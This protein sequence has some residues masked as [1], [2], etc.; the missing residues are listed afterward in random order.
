[1]TRHPA[2]GP[3]R[4]DTKHHTCQWGGL[5]ATPAS[6]AIRTHETLPD[7]HP[8]E[9]SQYSEPFTD[10]NA[11]IAVVLSKNLWGWSVMQKIDN[12]NRHSSQQTSV[13]F[14][15]I[16]GKRS[17]HHVVIFFFL[18]ALPA[19]ISCSSVR[20]SLHPNLSLSLFVIFFFFIS[21]ER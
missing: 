17:Q 20:L 7:H 11:T 4:G 2:N 1:M 13:K 6:A 19:I 12:W 14:N 9:P 21:W 10:N 5:Q 8:T 18:F 3:S 16:A 15:S